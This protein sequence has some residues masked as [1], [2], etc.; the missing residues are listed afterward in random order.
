MKTGEFCKTRNFFG[1]KHGICKVNS[2]LNG[3]FFL[4]KHGIFFEEFLTNFE[5]GIFFKNTEVLKIT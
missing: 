3:E 5:Q 2:F 1:K 4:E